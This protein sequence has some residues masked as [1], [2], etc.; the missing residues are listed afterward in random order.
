MRGTRYMCVVYSVHFVHYFFLVELKIILC[1]INK[2][3]AYLYAMN[4][5][6]RP[7]TTLDFLNEKT[8]VMQD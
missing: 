4:F 1:K 3:Y 8:F 5:Y 6:G 7:S 2:I